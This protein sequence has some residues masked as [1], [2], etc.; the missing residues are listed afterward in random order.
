MHMHTHLSLS[1]SHTHTHTHIDPVRMIE[2]IRDIAILPNND[3]VFTCKAIGVPQP[4]IK[5]F[6]SG[7]EVRG[8]E[9]PVISSA[10]NSITVQSSLR[11]RRVS[12]TQTG[13]VSCVAYHTVNGGDVSMA[14]SGANLIVL[15]T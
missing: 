4:R 9:N 14:T 13:P 10:L 11:L 3:A 2:S 12:E 15:S 1:P 8:D 6:I 5:W 7:V